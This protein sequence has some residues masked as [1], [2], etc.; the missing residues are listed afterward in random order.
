MFSAQVKK[1]PLQARI[2]CVAR[3][4]DFISLRENFSI[5]S[6]YISRDFDVIETR[7]GKKLML[8]AF[9]FGLCT[10]RLN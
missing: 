6:P 5:F 2:L 10:P 4:G 7:T 8:I 1:E 3:S 9:F